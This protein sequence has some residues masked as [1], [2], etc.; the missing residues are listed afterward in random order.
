MNRKITLILPLLILGFLIDLK[1]QCPPNIDWELGSYA[2]WK[3]YTGTCCPLSLPTLS[4]RVAGRHDLQTGPLIDPYGGFPCVAP[5]GGA[6]SLKLGN[7]ITGSQAER[8]RYHVPIP[9]GG[10]YSLVYRYAVVLNDPGHATA[11]QPRM[12]VNATDSNTGL[13]VPCAQYTYIASGSIPGFLASSTSSGGGAVYY[14][15]WTMGNMKFP[16][17]GGHTAIVDF[18]TGDCGYGGHWGYGYLDMTCGLFANQVIG[19]A[20]GTTVLAG[21]DGYASYVWK[22]SATFTTT[23]GTSAVVVI[24]APTIT[25]TYAVLLTPYTGYG[26]PDTLYT[27]VVPSTLTINSSNDT[28]ICSG[29]SVTLSAGAASTIMPITYSWSPST[30]LSCVTCSNPVANPSTSTSYTVTAV[31]GAGCINRDVVNL[32]VYPMP[33]AISGPTTLCPGETVTLTCGTAGAVWACSPTTVATINPASGALTG[34]L[35]GTVT[36]IAAT[37]PGG[38]CNVS[39]IETVNPLPASITGPTRVCAG[40][41]ITLA[42]ATAGGSWSAGIYTGIA[43]V[44]SSTGIVC[45]V[46]SAGGIAIITYT[47]P[48]TGCKVTRP[49]TVDAPPTGISGLSSVCVG[50]TI[51]LSGLPTGGTWS[52]ASGTISINSTSGDV[53]G[54]SSGT[55]SVT[56]TLSSGCYLTRSIT[57]NPLPSPIS[58][59]TH[60]CVGGTITLTDTDPTGIWSATNATAGVAGSGT[61]ATVTGAVAGVDTILY[62]TSGGCSASYVITIDPV[63][64]AIIVPSSVCVGGFVIASDVDPG[65]W[66]ITPTTRA[67]INSTSGVVTGVSAGAATITLTSPYGCIRTAAIS[68]LAAPAPITGTMTLC[69]GTTT[70]LADAT[71]P[72]SF[73]ASPVISAS[74]TPTGVVTG[75]AVGTQTITYTHTPSGC[76]A[77]AEV[78]VNTT[79]GPIVGN[80]PLCIGDNFIGFNSVSGGTWSVASTTIA[81]VNPLSTVSAQVTGV[82]AGTTTLSYALGAGCLSTTT[83]TVNSLPTVSGT[84]VVCQGSTTSLTGSP[85]GG[86]WSATGLAATV[87]STSGVVTGN[88]PGTS[89]VTYTSPTGCK[90]TVTVTVNPMPAVITGPMQACI[91]S[92]VTLSSST[93]GGT[94]SSLTTATGTVSSSGIVCAIAPPTITIKYTIPSTTCA[95]VTVVTVNPLPTSYTVTSARTSMC[96]GDAP[97]QICLTGSQSGVNYQLKLGATVVNTVAGTGAAICFPGVSTGGT[98]TVEAVNPTTTC[99]RSMSGSVT[100]TAYPASVIVGPSAVCNGANGTLTAVPSGGSWTSATPSCITVGASTGLITGVGSTGCTSVITYTGP[101]VAGGCI[102]T[103]TVSVS[104]SP[105]PIIIPSG[106][107]VASCVTVSNSVSGGTW[108]STSSL[109][110]INPSTGEV[111]GV[112]GGSA[113]ITY[114][115]GSGCTVMGTINVT[116]Q[117]SAITGPGTVC[118]GATITLSDIT[119]GGVWTTTGGTGSVS[120]VA[121][122]TTVSVLGVAAGTA[123]VSYIASGGTGC[124]IV[125]TITVNPMP[126]A[127]GGPQV[128]LGNTITLSSSPS[129]GTWN[130]PFGPGSTS[131]SIGGASGDFTAVGTATTPVAVT[132]TYTAIGCTRSGVVTVNPLPNAIVGPGRVCQGAAVTV[133]ATPAG[134]TWG[135]S[136]STLATI[137]P[138]GS[139]SAVVTGG[140]S[141]SST[142]A[143]IT[144]TLPTTCYR[145]MNV[146]VSQS[147]A[148]VVGPSGVCVGT[149]AAFVNPTPGGVWSSSNPAV[150][151]ISATTGIVATTSLPGGVVNISYTA[152]GCSAVAPFTVIPNPSPIV[153]PLSLCNGSC[154]VYTD[155]TP[156]GTWTS[157]L[158]SV[159][160]VD[161]VT[162]NVCGIS[163]GTTAI[164]YGVG[165]CVT[166][167]AVIIN[168]IPNIVGLNVI[169][170]GQSTMLV[171]T[172]LGG[173]WTSLNPTIATVGASSGLVTGVAGGTVTIRYRLTSGCFTDHIMTVNPA[174]AAITGPTSGCVGQMIL[175]ST[176]A[177][178]GVWSSSALAVGT[179]DPA[180]GI[181]TT[182]ASGTTGITYSFTGTGCSTTRMFTVNPVVPAINGPSSIC[183]GSSLIPYTDAAAGGAWSISSSAIATI[184]AGGLVSPVTLG[185]ATIT[186]TIPTTA[187]YATKNVTVIDTVSAI[188]GPDNVCQFG[189]ITLTDTSGAGTGSWSSSVPSVA[190]VSGGIVTGGSVGTAIITY[191]L[192]LGC[193]ARKTIT[194]NPIPGAIAGSPNVCVGS[195]VTYSSPTPG[196]VWSTSDA[197]V[198]DVGSATGVVSGINSGS[199]IIYYTLPTGCSVSI[200]VNVSFGPP[201][202]TGPNSFCVGGS[203]SYYNAL[204]GGT[205]SSSNPVVGPMDPTFGVLSGVA[206]GATV[207]S[208]TVTGFACP[209]TLPVTV[210]PTPSAIAGPDEVCQGQ[211]AGYFNSVPGGTW[212][213]LL[214]SVAV[215]DPVTGSLTANITGSPVQNIAM[216]EYSLGV[217]AGCTVNKTITVNPLPAAI[218][219]VDSMC[220]GQIVPM[221]DATPGGVWSSTVLAV[222]SIDPGGLLSGIAGGVTTVSYTNSYGCA[223]THPVT[224]NTSPDNITGSHNVC[225]GGNSILANTISGGTWSSSAPGIAAV[226]A[227]SG[228]VSGLA[229]GSAV[230]TYTTPGACYK[231]HDV[232]VNPLPL[233][234]TVSGGGNHCAGD[235]GVHVYLSGSVVGVNYMLYKDGS[236]A[237]GAFP[238]T[239]APL[240]FG[241]HTP[242]G[243]Y[244]V[245]AIS[246]STT[247]SVLMSGSAAI[248]VIPTV[249]PV[250]N[251]NIT[252]NDTV[253]AGATVSFLPV[254]VNGGTAPLYS[255]RVNGIPV[256]V[257]GTYSFIPADGDVVTVDMT[258]NAVCPS[259]ATVTGTATM[260]VK[261][262]GPPTATVA[263]SP[264]DTVCAG[265]SVTASA[266]TTHAGSAPAYTWYKNG[267]VVS[268]TGSSYTFPAINGDEIFVV[269]RSNDPCRTADVDSSARVVETVENPV[270]PVVVINAVPGTVISKGETTTLTAMVTKATNPTYQWYVNGFPVAGA[271]NASFTSATYSYPQQD[272]FSCA[273]TS[274]DVCEVT[275]H[276]WVYVRVVTTG[277]GQLGA[278]SEVVVVPNPTSGRFTIKGSLGTAIDEEVTFEVTNVIGQVVNKGSVVAKGG[279]INHEV[280]LDKALANGMYML[281][282]HTASGNMVFHLAVEQ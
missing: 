216:I 238:G 58:G 121:S 141:F 174:P 112:S 114:S 222:G 15:T 131:G 170:Q 158:P 189:T 191:S 269:M 150:A 103:R 117:P 264:N 199:A 130:I 155:P 172:A 62:T 5:G 218:F 36:V 169:C 275:T 252:P 229:L 43:S 177:T 41:C 233:V 202:I 162:G 266:V 30:G 32:T 276:E 23:Y 157:S 129:G 9:T 201:A 118:E 242:A 246:A 245:K 84:L 248:G 190:S 239:G 232:T 55:A 272:S 217:G 210:N 221:F 104:P 48:S 167:K 265:T 271:T 231:T 1:A 28:S 12:E 95:R 215:I 171:D 160:T 109:I 223:A 198:A 249:T 209:A 11:N 3:Y 227:G 152:S 261:P 165:S 187:C 73:S 19:C 120:L 147:P 254:P 22:D 24:T 74:V 17:L 212:N 68:V 262:F 214:P 153:G 47:V 83:V 90:R 101:S 166:T 16:G 206:M 253:C 82:A 273:V 21:P 124:S 50:A 77:Y 173:A 106:V 80:V 86:T 195:S 137:T 99:T 164:S 100:I 6:Y 42:D 8:V 125:K 72:G 4:G 52:S 67:T 279:K 40:Q 236:T 91:G 38:M 134:G 180:T 277:V 107:C 281:T 243:V 25:T 181:L 49:V 108:S 79:P 235:A 186:Y 260:S 213:S 258:S 34:I 178:G 176:T 76:K 44:G 127:F 267:V 71:I 75:V 78:T 144:Y 219:G 259:P 57:I 196:G 179:I 234:F 53:T 7:D 224:V 228:V 240:D 282:L 274:H 136:P 14:K 96:A 105:G 45:G 65:T 123:N 143:I 200:L 88:N 98:Y 211:S 251:M 29:S 85:A 241:L 203:G 31:D 37:G 138:L 226:G 148:A 149:G 194:V 268:Y 13:A 184:T 69:V 54:M 247:C 93:P 154:Q 182:L 151:A 18:T 70:S 225:L 156:L 255:W 20:S 10:I 257:S 27:R 87:N 61:T 250:V 94:W 56:Y 63:P 66:S 161:P 188:I 92:C 26:C 175:Q 2:N 33:S 97:I 193:D 113:A 263:L 46:A 126:T 230:I 163:T 204:A 122:G 220:S 142:P 244:T 280:T 183:M 119:A 168:P 59:P 270:N 132:V 35:S 256:S 116:P 192:G 111:C 102:A 145:T 207:V 110:T 51:T 64:A 146:T 208:Y 140:P 39:R 139:G 81:T 89:P 205:W 128:C 185:A 133:N 135:V 60:V 237:V 197:T 278:G 115:L 159:A